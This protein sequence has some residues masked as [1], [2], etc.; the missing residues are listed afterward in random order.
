MEKTRPAAPVDCIFM[1]VLL[2]L[3]CKAGGAGMGYH[4][5]GF[6][7]VGVDIEPQPNYPFEFVQA[8]AMTFDLRGFDAI[9]ASPP[10]QGY[11]KAMRH[12]SRGAAM[13]IDETRERL[14]ASGV[15]WVIENVQGAPLTTCTTLFGEHG[16]ILCGS[17]F[18]L[19]LW[20]HRLFETSFAI[21][22]PQACD[23]REPPINPTRRSSAAKVREEYGMNPETVWRA[24]MDV[25][26]MGKD[27]ARQAIPPSFTEWIGRQMLK[28]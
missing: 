20:R 12:L 25:P 5:A 11:S 13:L 10:C 26:W 3:F 21:R 22:P 15:P 6:D 16:V 2:D 24:E 4:R 17:M 28:A 27:E 7:V 9:H 8:D 18:G 23:H 14:N 19:K 1:P